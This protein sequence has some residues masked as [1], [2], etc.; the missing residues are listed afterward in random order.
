MMRDKKLPSLYLIPTVIISLGILVMLLAALFVS[1]GQ[2]K[3]LAE[4]SRKKPFEDYGLELPDDFRSVYRYKSPA[5]GF[6]GD[7]VTVSK[8]NIG[9]ETDFF[10][11]FKA[12]GNSEIEAQL[13][14]AMESAD[15]PKELYPDLS[16]G[17]TW[18]KYSCN[19][20]HNLLVIYLKEQ[21]EA[22]FVETII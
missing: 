13:S 21:S 8:Y 1:A 9:G 19:F 5:D 6:H 12:K 11:E 7:G 14:F 20:S 2:A 16:G 18:K 4:T 3:M 10:K 15:V 22:I 17:Y